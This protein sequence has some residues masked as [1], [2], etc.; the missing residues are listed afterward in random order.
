MQ[1]RNAALGIFV[2]VILLV[3]GGVWYGSQQKAS[4]DAA[5]SVSSLDMATSTLSASSSSSIGTVAVVSPAR[6]T[7]GLP[8]TSLPTTPVAQSVAAPSFT[9]T[10]NDSGALWVA[11]SIHSVGVSV[12][13]GSS[14]GAG[15]L[16]VDAIDLAHATQAPVMI[17]TFSGSLAA[18]PHTFSWTVPTGL[19]G[20]SYLVRVRWNGAVVAT[21]PEL[22]SIV[23]PQSSQVV[24]P[25]PA[26]VVSSNSVRIVSSIE[27]PLEVLHGGK[28]IPVL[29]FSL[30]SP[31]SAGSYLTD[32]SIGSPDGN[33]PFNFLE[34]MRLVTASGA[35]IPLEFQNLYIGGFP[36]WH[37]PTRIDL[38]RSVT[39]PLSLIGDLKPGV[40]TGTVI[41]ALSVN[42]GESSM[43][44][45]E[46][47][48]LG[49]TITVR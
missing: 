49:R 45:V 30:Q 36:L 2:V 6:P 29:A 17:G 42:G 15:T 48:A 32:I 20:N 34:N 21:A 5:S 25:I 23:G 33:T 12:K 31:G 14:Q 1:T 13:G 19:L 8:N 35:Q 16:I 46:G 11:G 41:A 28:D 7:P 10:L 44:G 47:I 27:Q 37:L 4:Q 9:V 40:A 3:V 18:M 22:V 39:I 43:Y 38:S 24:Q 26:P